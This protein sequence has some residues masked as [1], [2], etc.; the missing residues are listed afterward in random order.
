MFPQFNSPAALK[1]G[2]L[3][4]YPEGSEAE[5]M[6]QSFEIKRKKGKGA[7]SWA[8]WCARRVS[9]FLFSRRQ[10]AVHAYLTDIR[11]TPHTLAETAHILCSITLISTATY[12]YTWLLFAAPKHKCRSR[13][14][15]TLN[16]YVC[17][18]SFTAIFN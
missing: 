16:T 11:Q 9:Y 18:S 6:L 2:C 8:R 15:H 17:S 10:R 4:L 14:F 13:K 1:C 5:R 7:I 12:S 3:F